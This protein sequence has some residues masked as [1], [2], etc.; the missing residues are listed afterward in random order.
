MRYGSPSIDSRVEALVAQGCD[1]LIAFPLY[2]QH[3]AASTATAMTKCS[4]R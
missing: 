3:A 2:P 4:T 1:R